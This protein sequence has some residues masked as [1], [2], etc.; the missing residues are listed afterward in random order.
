MQKQPAASSSGRGDAATVGPSRPA[1]DDEGA[2]GWGGLGDGSADWGEVQQVGDW[3]EAGEVS[4][5]SYDEA[6]WGRYYDGSGQ[7]DNNSSTAFGQ[8]PP[9]QRPRQSS[10]QR[11]PEYEYAG[12]QQAGQQGSLYVSDIT[13]LSQQEVV[14][15]EQCSRSARA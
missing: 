9:Q 3:G 5:S 13:L 4:S 12:P 11:E 14:S 7:A 8:L 10:Q 6:G 15:G 1:Y 2:P